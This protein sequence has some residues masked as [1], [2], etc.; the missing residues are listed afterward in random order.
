MC[1]WPLRHYSFFPLKEHAPLSEKQKHITPSSQPGNEEQERHIRVILGRLFIIM[2]SSKVT[3]H[4]LVHW[5][6]GTVAIKTVTQIVRVAE[7]GEVVIARVE[8][9]FEF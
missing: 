1:L 5:H 9:I 4:G 8:N 6:C 7:E 3:A 2:R